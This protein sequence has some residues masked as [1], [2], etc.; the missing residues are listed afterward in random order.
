MACWPIDQPGTAVREVGT[1]ATHILDIP[2][3]SLWLD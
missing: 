2:I 1:I 3:W